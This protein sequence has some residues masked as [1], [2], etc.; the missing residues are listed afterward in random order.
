MLISVFNLF[1]TSF[2]SFG[3]ICKAFILSILIHRYQLELFVK[4]IKWYKLDKYSNWMLY[5]F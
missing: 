3:E 2:S 5:I 4:Q 1:S